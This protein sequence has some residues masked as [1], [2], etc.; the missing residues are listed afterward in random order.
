MNPELENQQRKDRGN[1]LSK[2]RWVTVPTTGV[3]MTVA[4]GD[5]GV[6]D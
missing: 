6:K 2:E 3:L 5:L 1:K 4:V